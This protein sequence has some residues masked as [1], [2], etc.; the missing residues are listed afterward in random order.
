MYQLKSSRGGHLWAFRIFSW[1]F[2]G[3][4]SSF[5]SSFQ[6]IW[7]YFST[8]SV[9]WKSVR[10]RFRGCTCLPEDYFCIPIQSRNWMGMHECSSGRL[11]HPRRRW[12]NSAQ[13][14][15]WLALMHE[16]SSG[17]FQRIGVEVKSSVFAHFCP[18]LWR[19]KKT[20]RTDVKKLTG[21]RPLT[22]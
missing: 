19:W 15:R 12:K 1:V 8:T 16:I 11:V 21:R 17:S 4:H 13:L 7:L 20:A 9:T 14:R 22:R 10:G 2:D 5:H 6:L 3:F 18:F